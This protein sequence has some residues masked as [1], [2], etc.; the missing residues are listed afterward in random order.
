MKRSTKE[1]FLSVILGKNPKDAY[2]ITIKNAIIVSLN[3]S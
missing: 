3:V 2:V 1:M